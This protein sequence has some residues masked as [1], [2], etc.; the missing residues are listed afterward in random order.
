ME[1]VDSQLMVESDDE[2]E[3]NDHSRRNKRKWSEDSEDDAAWRLD[4]EE[5]HSDWT[6]VISVNNDGAG[7]VHDTYHVHKM[8]LSV[9]SKKS[10]Y[11]CRA[12]QTK[13]VK[14]W[15]EKTSRIEL[16]P[17]AAKA[18]PVM[19]DYLYGKNLRISH[20]NA[21]PLYHLGDYF[22]IQPLRN[23]AQR[24]WETTMRLEHCGVYYEHAKIFDQE[25]LMTCVAVRC[26][27]SFRLPDSLEDR[28]MRLCE[29]SDEEF[30]FRVLELNR[31]KPNVPLS[32]ILAQFV[33]RNVDKV[34][35]DSFWKLTDR[36]HLPAINSNRAAVF[37]LQHAQTLYQANSNGAHR[38]TTVDAYDSLLE[39]C[40]IALEADVAYLD[41]DQDRESLANL[42][43]K[44]VTNLWFDTA[45]L[46][47]N[48]ERCLPSSIAVSCRSQPSCDVAGF[49]DGRYLRTTSF[50]YH[51][52]VY[53]KQGGWLNGVSA[54][55][56][57]SLHGEKWR[58]TVNCLCC[59]RQYSFYSRRHD[60]TEG[61][62]P[63]KEGWQY[64]R[65]QR[66]APQDEWQ[67]QPPPPDDS[68][69]FDSLGLRYIYT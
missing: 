60:E 45:H 58:L 69:V 34:S 65:Q 41:N 21:A 47:R 54:D 36:R 43:P 2:F 16:H 33:E 11:F 59:T 55:F 32:E 7:S 24:Y 30:W 19:L 68:F 67:G 23:T 40:H 14:E 8:V 17:L 48:V 53:A 51:A 3:S 46:L 39:R 28:A 49:I 31:G 9:G 64:F 44:I 29:V 63:P 12:F 52:P 35:A 20:E 18:F 38:A 57:I 42:G 37:F 27:N 50:R 62:L 10:D 13:N 66:D 1:D 22:G 25:D 26:T 4:P 56:V 61:L 5:S 15:Q 6:V